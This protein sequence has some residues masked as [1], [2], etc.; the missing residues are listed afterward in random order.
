M[1]CNALITKKPERLRRAMIKLLDD[2]QM[3]FIRTDKAWT[4]FSLPVNN[5]LEVP[6]NY[7]DDTLVMYG[8]AVEQLRHFRVIVTVF[9]AI[10]GRHHIWQKITSL[11]IWVFIVRAKNK[12]SEIWKEVLERCEDRLARWKSQYLPLRGRLVLINEVLD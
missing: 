3:T 11:L 8:A 6:S 12:A 9:E 4:Q 5:G 7:L 2:F 1:T 10:S